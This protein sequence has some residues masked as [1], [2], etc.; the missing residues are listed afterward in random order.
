MI[1]GAGQHVFPR[2]QI[3]IAQFFVHE[4]AFGESQMNSKH[5]NVQRQTFMP[6]FIKNN[7]TKER[8][9]QIG[10]IVAIELED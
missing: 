10:Y 1:L 3:C 6:F 5:F 9:K 8:V 2:R 4:M 7:S